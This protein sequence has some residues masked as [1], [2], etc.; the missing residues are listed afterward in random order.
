MPAYLYLLLFIS[1]LVITLIIVFYASHKKN[2]H[3]E[4]YMEGVRN[5]NNGLYKIALDN[6]QAA[7]AEIRKHKIPNTLGKKIDEKIKMLH[8]I[9]E[10]EAQ[11]EQ[12][13]WYFLWQNLSLSCYFLVIFSIKIIFPVKK[14]VG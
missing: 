5:E 4:L 8:T 11:F 14:E 12:S 7:L 13:L 2:I 3:T 9:I 1:L 6:Y 10:Y